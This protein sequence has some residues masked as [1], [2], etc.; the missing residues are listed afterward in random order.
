MSDL[1]MC[2]C[3]TF[4]DAHHPECQVRREIERLQVERDAIR[5]E[6]IE[7]CKEVCRNLVLDHAGR[8]DLTADQ[9]AAA[10]EALK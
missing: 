10:I 9:C 7:Q 1:P 5:L 2:E 6:T 8:A 3:G 4:W